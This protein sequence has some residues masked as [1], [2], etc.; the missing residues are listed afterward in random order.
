MSYQI[1]SVVILTTW[2]ALLVI[3]LVGR[4]FVRRRFLEGSPNLRGSNLSDPANRPGSL[5]SKAGTLFVFTA[6]IATVALVFTAAISAPVSQRL[7]WMR[8]NLPPWVQVLGSGLFVLNAGWGLLALLFNPNYTPMF[9]P[10]R[11]Q[12]ML[13]RRGP[14]AV[15][16]HPRYTGEA[17]LNVILFMLTG[18]WLPLLGALGW[19]PMYYQ[20]RA[21]EESLTTL[22]GQEYE[23]YCQRTGMFFPRIRGIR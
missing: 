3:L 1:E 10:M 15:V 2:A 20:A 11:E 12:F 7:D 8:V 19:I 23:E 4:S 14:Y 9:Q 18:I 5:R 17:W 13:A 22:A 6:N 21:E 16:R